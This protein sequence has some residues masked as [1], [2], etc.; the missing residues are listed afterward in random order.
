MCVAHL[1]VIVCYKISMSHLA[2]NSKVGIRLFKPWR[3][4]ST[5]LLINEAFDAKVSC[6]S[7]VG[8]TF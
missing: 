4:I 1:S 8:F 6:R 2:V 5:I 3:L 7:W